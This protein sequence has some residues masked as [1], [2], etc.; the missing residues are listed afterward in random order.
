ARS[1]VYSTGPVSLP[2][3]P[4]PSSDSSLRWTAPVA[5]NFD[6]LLLWSE[7]SGTMRLGE[8]DNIELE[9]TLFAPNATLQLEVRDSGPGFEVAA[10]VVAGR[11]RLVGGK[12][13]TLRPA[14]GR[15]TSRLTRQ[16]RLI[17]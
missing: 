15:A 13:L 3:D 16:T 4:D 12:D 2:R 9:G 1:F 6:D 10:Q 11:V 17:R 5:G 7:A 14:A 8:Q